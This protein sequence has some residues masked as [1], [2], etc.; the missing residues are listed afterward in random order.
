MA[1]SSISFSPC[2][3]S[4]SASQLRQNKAV[5]R[6][7][8]LVLAFGNYMNGGTARGQADGFSLTVLTKL[9][10][11]KT[12]DNSSTLIAYLVHLLCEDDPD[13]GTDAAQLPVPEATLFKQYVVWDGVGVVL[14]GR[15]AGGTVGRWA[16]GAVGG[17]QMGRPSWVHPFSRLVWHSL[18]LPLLQSL[19]ISKTGPRLPISTTFRP[20]WTRSTRT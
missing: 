11:V 16:G 3:S 20:R 18:R 14:V 17:A 12:Q 1:S 15:W 4:F 7:L 8:G 9:R 6:I 5:H 2:P 13:S 19:P 10:D